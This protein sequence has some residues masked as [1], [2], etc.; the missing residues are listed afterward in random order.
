MIQVRPWTRADL[1]VL[2]PLLAASFGRSDFDLAD[3]WEYFPDPVPPGWL[4]AWVG[5]AEPLGFLR[6]FAAGKGVQVA[7]LYA[8]PGPFRE[9]VWEALLCGLVGAVPPISGERLR[10]DL[11]PDDITLR[12]VLDRHLEVVEVHEYL[13]L[14]REVEGRG[15]HPR[16]P[17]S[18]EDAQAAAEVLSTLKPYPPDRLRALFSQGELTLTRRDGRV[19]GAAHVEGRGEG[20]REVVT[21]AVRPEARG[22]GEGTR[23]LRALLMGQPPG[24][25]RLSLQVRADN[26]AACRLY[27][28]Q[29]FRE[30]PEKREIW[31]FA[32]PPRFS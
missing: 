26:H 32:R 21:L 18:P 8:S 27:V 20:E 24:T 4:T 29:G 6:F 15:Q 2:E 28:R 9:D 12:T 22:T 16:P 5:N 19:V 1:R 10:F 23:L 7:E 31:V 30:L 17:L 11:P 25:R 13:R 3:E 14:E